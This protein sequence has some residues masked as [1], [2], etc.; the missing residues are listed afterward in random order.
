VKLAESAGRFQ[1][2]VSGVWTADEIR[3]QWNTMVKP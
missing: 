2:A 1:E 3:E